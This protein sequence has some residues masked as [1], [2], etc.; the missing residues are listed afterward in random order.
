MMFWQAGPADGSRQRPSLGLIRSTPD[1]GSG[2]N[3]HGHPRRSSAR[4]GP[5]NGKH[6]S[7]IANPDCITYATTF[8]S[9]TGYLATTGVSPQAQAQ[10]GRARSSRMV[11]QRRELAPVSEALTQPPNR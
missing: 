4:S 1:S 7:S 11:G 10:A 8:A 6:R 3:L 2:S 5:T 9:A